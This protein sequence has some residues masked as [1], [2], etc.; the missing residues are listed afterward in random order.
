[1][2]SQ[3][4]STQPVRKPMLLDESCH[5]RSRWSGIQL[6]VELQPAM[7][8]SNSLWY[9]KCRVKN[10]SL[11]LVTLTIPIHW[12]SYPMYS[13]SPQSFAMIFSSIF[14][15]TLTINVSQVYNHLLSDTIPKIIPRLICTLNISC[16]RS[17]K[18]VEMN[19][20]ILDLLDI[21]VVFPTNAWC[22][23]Q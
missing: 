22:C 3:Y 21:H 5:M 1:M 23:H 12:I 13:L 18:S 8:F 7:F 14:R 17:G 9:V 20:H 4:F 11:F 15:S 2:T 10:L 16:Q 19:K 6:H